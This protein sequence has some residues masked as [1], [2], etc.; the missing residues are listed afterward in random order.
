MLHTRMHTRMKIL[1]A[2]EDPS[3]DDILEG[4]SRSFYLSL[5]ILPKQVRTQ[6]SVAYLVARAADTIADTRLVRRARRLELLAGLREALDRPGAHPRFAE[7]VRTELIGHTTVPSE[8]ILL[9]RLADCLVYVDAFEPSDSERVGRVLDDLIS[10]MERDL[11]RFDPDGELRALETLADLDEYVYYAAGCVGEFWSV[12]IAAHLPAVSRMARP[13]LKA[14]GVRLGKALQ[15]VNVL[16]DA[17]ADLAA[18]RCYFPKELLAAHGLKP[19]DLADP[20][21]RRMARPVIDR[22]IAIGRDHIDAAFPYVLAIP[23]TE[24][25]LRLSALWPLWIGIETIAR[26]AALEDPLDPAAHVKI[27]RSDVY[28]IIAESTA[29]VGSDA[30]LTAAQR[31]RRAAI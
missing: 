22:V 15:I 31:R 14:R 10:G 24:P 2:V 6:V 11:E 26:Y 13:D 5:A 8:R 18:K 9:E 17:P 1:R 16:R 23:R 30:L 28:K 12:T 21:R 27:P 3:L 7:S 29:V 25:R 20:A 19:K 4:V